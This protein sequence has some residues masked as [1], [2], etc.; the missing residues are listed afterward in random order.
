MDRGSRLHYG[1]LPAWWRDAAR[2]YDV[3]FGPAAAEELCSYPVLN[4]GVFALHRDAPHW[5]AWATALNCAV[6]HGAGALTDQ[7]ALNHAV[8]KDGL[9]DRTALLPAWCSWNCNLGPPTWD[10]AT[11]RLVESHLP[12]TPIGVLHRTGPNKNEVVEVPLVSGGTAPVRLRFPP[13][14][15]ESALP[16]GPLL[17]GDYV[18]PGLKLIVP[19]VRFPNVM[20]GDPAGCAWPHLR[21]EIP[22]RW[23][24]DR[25]SPKIGFVSRDEAMILYNTA[26]RFRGQR[27]LEI[28]CWLGWSMCHLALGGVSLDVLDPALADPAIR[29]S[30]EASLVAAGVRGRVNLV[31]AGSPDG[32]APLASGRRWS[33]MFVDGDHEGDAPVRHMNGT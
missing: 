14:A 27:V 6:R 18:S 22:H 17:P 4:A 26:L 20:K 15:V 32:I 33:L 7:T 31:A 11:A 25:R 30:V 23:Y 24:V 5:A 21:K 8:Y 28:G 1:A 2:W 13:A 12:H 29:G 10:A 16:S 9:L 19:D 3:A